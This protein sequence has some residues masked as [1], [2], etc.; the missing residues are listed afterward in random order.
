MNKLQ[1][2]QGIPRATFVK[3]ISMIFVE[4]IVDINIISTKKNEGDQS[5]YSNYIV[6]VMSESLNDQIANAKFSQV[7]TISN[8]NYWKR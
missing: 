7:I 4:N 5:P 6:F 3:A 1:G 2:S 8:K